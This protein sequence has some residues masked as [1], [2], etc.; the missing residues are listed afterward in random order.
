MEARREKIKLLNDMKSGR[1]KVTDLINPRV[2]FL[3]EG[4]ISEF[5][6]REGRELSLDQFCKTFRAGKDLLFPVAQGIPQEGEKTDPSGPILSKI[7]ELIPE[8]DTPENREFIEYCNDLQKVWI[9]KLGWENFY[10]YQTG[11]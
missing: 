2:F 8:L 11:N 5:A 9:D 1:V 10:N 3:D 6:E 4:K 7:I